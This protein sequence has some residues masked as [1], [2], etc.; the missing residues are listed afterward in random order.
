MSIEVP[1]DVRTVLESRWADLPAHL[2]E[3]HAVEGYEQGLLSLAQER[4]LLGLQTRWD[5]Q[6]FLG[7]RGIAVFDFE[8]SE[9]DREANLQRNAA[10]KPTARE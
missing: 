9:L 1:D 10:S 2:R 4:R 6:Q 7:R 5:A 8:P 3:N